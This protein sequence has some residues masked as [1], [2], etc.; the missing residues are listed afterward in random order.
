MVS[1][2]RRSWRLLVDRIIS[3]HSLEVEHKLAS[4]V[5]VV[6]QTD[7]HAQAGDLPKTRNPP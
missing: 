1:E 2:A 6:Q 7:K 3:S 5:A 4:I